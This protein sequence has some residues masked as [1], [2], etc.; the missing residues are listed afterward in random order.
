MIRK[1]EKGFTLIELL[2]VIAIIGILAAIAIPQFA[3]YRNNAFCSQIESDVTNAMIAA[4]GYYAENQAYPAT[5][6][7]ANFTPSGTN[8]VAYSGDGT[9]ATPFTATGTDGS[10]K[11]PKGTTYTFAQGTAP[12][13]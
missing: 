5:T 8:T 10:G 11:C 2:V 9:V 4:E 3:A 13:Y 12:T 6:A 1:N 7:D